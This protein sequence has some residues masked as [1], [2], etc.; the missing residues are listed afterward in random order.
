MI[1]ILY[2]MHNLYCVAFSVVVMN[3]FL[4]VSSYATV[5]FATVLGIVIP[6]IVSRFKIHNNR[7]L[8]TVMISR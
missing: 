2:L 4:G 8:S 3:G 7:L 5:I 6:M 1:Y